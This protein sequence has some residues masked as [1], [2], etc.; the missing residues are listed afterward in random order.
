MTSLAEIVS[1]EGISERSVRMTLSLT[2]L[3]PDLVKAIAEGTLPHGAGI[4]TLADA[5]MDWAA[6][7]KALTAGARQNR[8]SA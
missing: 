2:F 7:W 1:R 6:Q 5:P 4:T 3:A 8:R